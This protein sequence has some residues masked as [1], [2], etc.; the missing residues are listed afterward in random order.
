MYLNSSA[1]TIQRELTTKHR[2]VSED[3][4]PDDAAPEA[5]TAVQDYGVPSRRQGVRQSIADISLLNMRQVGEGGDGDIE[6]SALHNGVGDIPFPVSGYGRGAGVNPSTS[7]E[8]AGYTEAYVHSDNVLKSRELTAEELRGLY[9]VHGFMPRLS[10]VGW[11]LPAE[12]IEEHVHFLDAKLRSRVQGICDRLCQGEDLDAK[13]VWC[14]LRCSTDHCRQIFKL[15]VLKEIWPIVLLYAVYTLG[16]QVYAYYHDWDLMLSA[17]HQD[18]IYYPG[19]VLAFLLSF[20]ASDCMMRYQAGCQYCFE[21]EKSL[22]NL[23][24]EVIS[25]L[26]PERDDEEER[27]D[28]SKRHHDRLF[29]RSGLKRQ[30][31]KH[32]FRRLAQLLFACAARDL[33]DSAPPDED[34]ILDGMRVPLAVTEVEHAAI[35]VTHSAYGHVFRVFLVAAWMRKLVKR[36]ADHQLF[37]DP[38]VF[39][40]AE[41]Y[42]R[43]FNSSWFHA[44]QV[45]Y[46]HMPFPI[47][48][49]LWLLTNMMALVLPWEYVSV[50]QWNTWLLSVFI[51]SAFFGIMRIASAM[52]N[53]FGFDEDDIPIWNVAEHLDE[54]ICIIM[55][56]SALDS[57]GGENLYRSMLEL[58]SISLYNT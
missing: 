44:R 23:A 42:L 24:F 37:D 32:E 8:L 5:D 51:S 15:G 48:H 16:V 12:E 10:T 34:A 25:K 35:R 22:R 45:A 33:N 29:V 28:P 58:D 6:S 43:Q 36:I 11:P 27:S 13:T 46:T 52:E 53:P 18:S 19:I 1:V 7:I 41:A 2:G 56:Y 9:K 31:F 4:S 17:E 40:N 54:E 21:M 38:K 3:G 39:R 30:Y 26:V 49:V 14:R 47:I 20:R 50:C 57:V 55:F